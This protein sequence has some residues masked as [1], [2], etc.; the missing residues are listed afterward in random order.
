M[1]DEL[2]DVVDERDR[3]IGQEMRSAVHARGLWHR[4]VHVFLATPDGKLIVQRRSALRQLLP[5]GLDG[6]VSEHVKAGEDYRRAAR[7]GLAEELGLH[8]VAACAL[9][10]FRMTYG[11]NDNEISTLYEGRAEPG[12]VSV[13]PQ[14]VE[15]IAALRLDEL[16]ALLASGR[17]K[18]CPWFVELLRWYRGESS[19]LEV[20]RTYKNDRLLTYG[21][22]RRR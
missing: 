2:L 18:F 4:G 1:P 3:V 16:E 15:D 9:V 7:R 21:G 5:L 14:E 17:E 8:A 20:L 19:A 13:D 12:R 6:S 10:R 11:P 22:G